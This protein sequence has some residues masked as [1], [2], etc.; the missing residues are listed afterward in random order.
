MDRVERKRRVNLAFDRKSLKNL[1]YN[2]ILVITLILGLSLMVLSSATASISSDH[3]F[4]VKKQLVMILIGVVAAGFLM[5]FAYTKMIRYH[6]YIYGAAMAMLATVMVIGRASHGAR[7]WIP[8]GSF[9]F[10]PSEFA[11]VMLIV[12]FA[13]FLV[14]RQGQLQTFRDL[15]PCFAYFLAPI[16]LVMAQPDLGT[17]LV[18]VAIMFGMLFLAGARPSLLLLLLGGSL[19]L[20]AVALVLHFSSLHLPLPLKEYQITRLVVFINPYLDPQGSGYNILQSLVA[21]G[22]GGFWG[23]GLY[24]GSQVQLNFLPEHH[25]DFIFSVVGE[26]L[27]FIGSVFILVLYFI[28]IQ[29]TIKIAFE[30]KDLYGRLLVGGVVCM[31]LFHILQNVGMTIGVMP[32][33]GIPCPFLSSGGSFM[34]TNLICVG[35]VLNIHLRREKMLF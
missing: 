1:D 5:S 8:I 18:F 6:N 24:H 35:L 25:T 14:K 19:A 3:F 12:C 30:A 31:W 29:R 4:Y 32:I 26:E 20:V 17:A 22:S 11:K 9:Q 21:I 23:K 16:A 28:L 2:L 34:I 15:L 33:T 27:G 13:T 7:A 10:Q